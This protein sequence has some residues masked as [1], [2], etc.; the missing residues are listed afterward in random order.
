M[1]TPI[2]GT[3]IIGFGNKARNGKDSAAAALV[4]K[5]P[6]LVQ[7]FSFA[8]ALRVFAR[9]E[10]GMTEKDSPLLQKLGDEFRQKDPDALKRSVYWAIK[11]AAPRYALITDVRYH[12]EVD[13]VRALGGYVVQVKRLNPDG[14]QFIDPSRSATHP[15]EVA[16]DRYRHW[17]FYVVAKDG[18]LGDL[19]R[20][21]LAAFD[22]IRREVE[23][24]PRE[25]R[26]VYVAGP[27][28]GPHHWAIAENI[29]HAERLALKV[30]A[31]GAVALCPHLNTIHFQNALPD[32]VWLDG[33]LELL[34]RCDAIIMTDNWQGSVGA[35]TEHEF[36]LRLGIP[37]FYTIEELT[38]WLAVTP[39]VAKAA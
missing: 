6:H 30:W 33:D 34:R 39:G 7:R 16:L 31:A 38:K 25:L 20:Q 1:F 36:A 24:G 32:E 26:T 37:V 15:T 18:D 27:F 19:T 23:T 2:E 11:E 21:T 13:F 8:D 29:R 12:D 3:T 4:R 22:A 28:R 9:V 5:Y 35:R 17:D 10:R 14:S